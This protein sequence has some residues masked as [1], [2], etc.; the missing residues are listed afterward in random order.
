MRIYC[1]QKCRQSCALSACSSPTDPTG[2]LCPDY[3]SLT[4]R[5]GNITSS[6]HIC[7]L[8]LGVCGSVL[9][10]RTLFEMPVFHQG[11]TPSHPSL[12]LLTDLRPRPSFPYPGTL[13]THCTKCACQEDQTLDLRTGTGLCGSH[14]DSRLRFPGGSIR[15]HILPRLPRHT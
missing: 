9:S 6:W 10:Q 15:S 11:I 8:P 3:T 12:P 14:S 2:F 1:L 5:A 13:C 7:F 4:S